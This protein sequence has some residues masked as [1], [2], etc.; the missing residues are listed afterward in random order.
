MWLGLGANLG[1]PAEALRWAIARL[2]EE[3]AVVE[4]SLIHI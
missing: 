3:G 1:E 4:L 2:G